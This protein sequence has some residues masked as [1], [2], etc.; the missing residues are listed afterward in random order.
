MSRPRP[1]LT[2]RAARRLNA[3]AGVAA[4]A[5]A[6]SLAAV[7]LWAFFATGSL[8]VAASLADSALDL[9]ASGT[10]LAAVIYAAKPADDEH[11][12]GHGSA[13][14]LAALGQALIVAISAFAIAGTAALRLSGDGTD[15]LRQEEDGL[16]AMLVA[17][18][19]TAALV[20]WQSYVVRRTGSKVVAADRLHYLSDLLPN[21]GAAAALAASA[22]LKVGHLDAVV[23]LVAAA[24]LLLGASKIALGAW[25]ALMDRNADPETLTRLAALADAAEGIAG[26][27]DLKT[28]TS[29]SRLFVQIHVEIDGALSLHEAHARGARLRHAMIEAFPNA[30]V[31]VHKDPAR[32]DGTGAEGA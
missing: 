1:I 32:T 25:N 6:A 19:A 24:A 20:S 18:G 22:Y 2:G 5:L 10:G 9:I 12:F 16:I 17:A 3:S 28:R 29:G 8:S 4:V 15:P 14:D 31:I 30:E 11:A 21:L 13:E 26:W 7:K 27:H 23:A